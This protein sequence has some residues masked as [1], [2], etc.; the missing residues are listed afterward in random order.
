MQ[1]VAR[2]E[3]HFNFALSQ[4]S[5]DHP[6]ITLPGVHSDL[7]GGYRTLMQEE[8]MVTPLQSLEV[9]LEHGVTE[10]SIYRDAVEA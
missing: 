6:E 1:L 10:T 3:K 8:L 7:G 5:P 4:I 2:D 9:A